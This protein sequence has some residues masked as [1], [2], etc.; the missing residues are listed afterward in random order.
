MLRSIALLLQL[1]PASTLPVQDQ[2]LYPYGIRRVVPQVSADP[3]MPECLRRVGSDASHQYLNGKHQGDYRLGALSKVWEN[4]RAKGRSCSEEYDTYEFGVLTGKGLKFATKALNCSGTG[5]RLL[6]GF[7]SF[8]GL[9]PEDN[10]NFSA[11]MKRG[12][13]AGCYSSQSKEHQSKTTG[14][15]V[16]NAANEDPR[17]AVMKAVE[18]FIDDPRLRLVPGFFSDSL[19]AKLARKMRPASYVDIDSDLYSSTLQALDWMATHGLIVQGTVISY[20]DWRV[21]SEVSGGEARA[22]KEALVDKHGFKLKALPGCHPDGA[23][24]EVLGRS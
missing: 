6:W 15:H 19:T 3:A 13:C 1:A 14:F 16:H 22:H 5:A 24:F 11:R 2:D 18:S 23:C 4:C 12:Y 10:S 9:P 17:V 8:Q 7:D 21:S 20:D